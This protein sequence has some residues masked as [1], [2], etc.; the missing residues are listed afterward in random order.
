MNPPLD[1]AIVDK[2]IIYATR[3][4]QGTGR[5]GKGYPYIVHPLEAMAIVAT[6][7]SDPE[8]LCAAV[9]HD[10]VEDT[11]ATVEDIRREFG[12]R[13]AQLVA[14]ETD[15]KTAT[16]GTP[17]T[18]QQRKQRDMDLLRIAPL[19]V[20]IVAL[21]DKLSNMR[22]IVRDYAEQGD[23]VWQ[24]F[25]IKDKASH[26]WRYRGL[27]DALSDLSATPAYQ[28]FSHLIDTLFN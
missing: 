5:K 26:A 25:R 6:L 8:L 21:G 11:P 19:D 23:A 27:R 20:K 24:L 10:T 14:A 13:V 28:E 9:L 22:A 4:H 3:A 15:Q 12:P 18:W 16:D 17:L 1:T 2:A 7:S